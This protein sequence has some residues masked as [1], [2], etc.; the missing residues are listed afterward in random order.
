MQNAKDDGSSNDLRTLNF[1]LRIP[2]DNPQLI[3]ED[4]VIK[5]RAGRARPP[6]PG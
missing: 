3:R 5:F 2:G 1:E 6:R 4:K